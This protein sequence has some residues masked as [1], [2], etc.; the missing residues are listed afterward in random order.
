MRAAKWLIVAV[1]VAAVVV[2]AAV[3][4]D[5][6]LRRS[7]EQ[8]V[9]QAL[10]VHLN[11]PEEPAVSLGGSPFSLALFSRTIPSAT[12]DAASVPMSI[13]GYDLTLLDVHV[14]GTDLTFSDTEVVIGQLAAEATLSYAD[15]TTL[16]GTPV[17][18]EDPGRLR[19][20]YT[21]QVFGLQVEAAA[22]AVPQVDVEAQTVTLD[23]PTVS[24]AGFALTPEISQFVI[25]QLVK[26]I[27]VSLEDGLILQ[28]VEPTEAG[29]VLHLTA[30]DFRAPLS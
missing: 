11:L 13:S 17:G 19:A 4:A 8:R 30:T 14:D 22:S 3:I 16:A 15:L 24:V 9:A 2:A 25:N 10:A 1:V 29:L 6:I 20:T 28:S 12:A 5:G 7:V 23:D 18:Y 21:T 26:P 27:D